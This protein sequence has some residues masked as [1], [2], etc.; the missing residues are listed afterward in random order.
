MQ[1]NMK[2]KKET[3]QRVYISDRHLATCEVEGIADARI[4]ALPYKGADTQLSEFTNV[5]TLWHDR[6]E[7]PTKEGTILMCEYQD[8][9]IFVTP[10][11]WMLVIKEAIESLVKSG[12]PQEEIDRKRPNVWQEA[13]PDFEKWCYLEDILPKKGL[14]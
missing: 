14:K 2:D 8:G 9:Q 1:N 3:L 4:N 10:A 6:S 5:S 12:F 11:D 13:V 7:E